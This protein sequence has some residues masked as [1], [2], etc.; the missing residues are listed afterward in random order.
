MLVVRPLLVDV[1]SKVRRVKS[2]SLMF[3][4]PPFFH[5]NLHLS[6][7]LTYISHSIQYTYMTY[8]VRVHACTCV[9]LY[10]ITLGDCQ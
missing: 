3:F 5:A 8:V 4:F 2:K 1:G 7:S 6:L 10:C 9:L